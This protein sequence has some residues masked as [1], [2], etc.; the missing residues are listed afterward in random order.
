MTLSSK[1]C[2]EIDSLPSISLHLFSFFLFVMKI[3][4]EG[5]YTI[6]YVYKAPEF[7]SSAAPFS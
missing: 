2:T 4:Y 5:S 3:I 6:F 1:S 7:V